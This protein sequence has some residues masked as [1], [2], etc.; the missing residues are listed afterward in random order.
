M[1]IVIISWQFMAHG[2][3][4]CVH[5][6]EFGVYLDSS[7]YNSL[8]S[9]S[10]ERLNHIFRNQLNCEIDAELTMHVLCTYKDD[11]IVQ[12]LK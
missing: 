10:L 2:F 4:I 11:S 6:Y 9:F 8:F 7:T 5:H 12:V 1:V 3:V